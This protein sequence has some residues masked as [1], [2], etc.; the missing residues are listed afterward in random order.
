MELA[1]AIRLQPFWTFNDVRKLV[2]TTEQ[3]QMKNSSKTQPLKQVFPTRGALPLA[4]IS[5]LSMEQ[6]LVRMK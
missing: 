5:L 4:P 2:I 1:D 3:K 6:V